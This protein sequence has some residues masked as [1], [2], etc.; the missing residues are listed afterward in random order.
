MAIKINTNRYRLITLLYIV[1]VCLSVLNI[2]S[3]LL[4]S[5]YYVINTM[6]YEERLKLQQINY[7]D[8]I[9]NA[10]VDLQLSDSS[11]NYL[12]LKNRIHESY[13]YVKQ[14]DDIIKDEFSKNNMTIYEQ[15]YSTKSI[16]RILVK[17]S[18]IYKLKD[19][20]FSIGNLVLENTYLR[21]SS[22]RNLVPLNELIKNKTGKEYLWEDFFFNHKP[23][24]ISYLQLKRFLLLLLDS[25][26]SCQRNLLKSNKIYSSFYVANKNKL[27]YNSQ[28]RNLV[29][30]VF[31]NPLNQN[32]QN[33][34]L[35][36]TRIENKK[37][38]SSLINK[39]ETTNKTLDKLNNK[40][41]NDSFYQDVILALRS[42]NLYVGIKN[43]FLQFSNSD[44]LSK[45]Q[46]ETLPKSDIQASANS[47]NIF[48][49]NSGIYKVIFYD[50]R[51]KEKKYLFEKT[52]N[53]YMLPN[54]YVKLFGEKISKE[55]ISINDLF[56]ANRLT[57]SVGLNEISEF[58]GKIIG[59]RVIKMSNN[60][61]QE[62]FYNYGDV[63]QTGTQ[64][65]LSS[66]KKGDVLV[67]DNITVLLSDGS[68]RTTNQ[69]VYKIT[70]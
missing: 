25:E 45:I 16:E 43:K 20:M 68:T 47:L 13:L 69:L 29:P 9:L 4:D 14:I 15:F 63:F 58:P 8:S 11:K 56:T 64:Q 3:N 5:N 22:I 65:L 1:F 62:N 40:F 10:E 52:F 60:Q 34:A 31:S 67:F 30:Q 35:E 42:E 66:L 26:I 24:A 6:E 12:G 49:K 17:D 36:D 50:I 21:D 61:S 46:I 54:P 48:F 51:D 2:P 18:L 19:Q 27:I 38:E 32:Q 7:E 59:Y 55:F 39:E 23:V 57:A 37:Q 53:V 41:D 44:I 28:N 33:E 70:Q